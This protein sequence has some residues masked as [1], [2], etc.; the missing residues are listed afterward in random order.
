MKPLLKQKEP[1]E[2]LSAAGLTPEEITRAGRLYQETREIHYRKTDRMFSYLLAAEWI[3]GILV[4]LWLSPYAWDGKQ[5]VFHIHLYLAVLM[6][7]GITLFPIFL[8]R[9]RPGWVVTRHVIAVSQMLWS[10]L[11]IH[12]TGGRIETHFHV[13]VS[14]AFL[15]F[16][17]DWPV[18]ITATGVAA[19]DH[20]FRGL[21]YPESVYGILNP[22]WWRFL[23]HAFWMLFED[24]VL[25][26]SCVTGVRALR[27]TSI[28]QVK[29]EAVGK[30]RELNEMKNDL[31]AV[32]SHQLKTPVAEINGYVENLLEGL[33]GPLTAR[34]VEY[35][36]DMREIGKENFRLISDLLSVS[37]I[38]RGVLAVDLKPVSLNHLV[39]MAI[40]DYDQPMLQKGLTLVLEPAL[41][42][43]MALA[44]MGKTVETLRNVINNAVKC[45]D[46]GSITISVK[47]E[48]GQ[49]L[50]E[51]RDTGI[52]MSGETLGRLFTKARV[53]G[54][55]AGR[56]GAGL[57]LFIAKSFMN[58]QN[59]D[60][61]VTSELGIGTCFCLSL[62]ASRE[63]KGAAL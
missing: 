51:V 25:V 39:E 58:L 56:A 38:E 14:L 6:G 63:I 45:T 61:T 33:A 48:G 50:I 5:K 62:P 31:I 54:K 59:G 16:Y 22:E 2:D 13:F 53:M 60:I 12:L 36:R 9:L 43:V 18:L 57:G 1:F 15:A 4:A 40:R 41:K 34:Q 7:G 8:A 24:S 49:G 29:L 44:D 46:R 27:A 52:G 37:K 30:L 35:L 21:Y 11:F 42:D 3:A 28:R 23:E 26:W 47:S 32:V 17:L 19:A 55:E 10:A 20:F